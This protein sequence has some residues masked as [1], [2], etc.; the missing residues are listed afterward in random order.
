MKKKF[1]YILPL[2]EIVPRD[3]KR[4]QHLASICIFSNKYC[5]EYHIS[6]LPH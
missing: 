2:Q 1:Y 5:V 6:K 3:S 4:K